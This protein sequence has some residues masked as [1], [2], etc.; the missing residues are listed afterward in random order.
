MSAGRW[1]CS[2]FG[3]SLGKCRG[4]E[5]FDVVRDERGRGKAQFPTPV[6]GLI[7]N[8]IQEVLRVIFDR[9]GVEKATVN[10]KTIIASVAHETGNRIAYRVPLVALAGDDRINE[11]KGRV[12]TSLV[13]WGIAKKSSKIPAGG[14]GPL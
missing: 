14:V 6:P 2:R 11:V 4:E 8:G 9:N 7:D 3:S 1:V 5:R 12:E 10:R 13:K